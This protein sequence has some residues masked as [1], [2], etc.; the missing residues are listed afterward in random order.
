MFRSLCV[1]LA[2]KGSKGIK[3]KN[4]LEMCGKP[5]IAYTIEAA[6]HS[7]VF[8]K[9]IVSTDCQ[10]IA[11][12]ANIY[13]AETPFLRPQNLSSDNVLSKYAVKHA[14]EKC[15]IIYDQKFDIIAELQCTSPLRNSDHVKQSFHK[16]SELCGH[17]DS[18]I[19]VCKVNH[20]HPNKIKRIEENTIVDLCSH[21][22]ENEIGRRQNAANYYS[23]NGAIFMM[24]RN[25][26]LNKVSRVGDK[27]TYYVMEEQDSVNIDSPVDFKLAEIILREKLNG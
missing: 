21:F 10:H 8:D 15:E 2:R 26:I 9:V 18:L 5:L 11:D 25:C 27:S 3:N 24:T 12:I 7:N 4:I 20:F 16:F 17:Y 6:L 23:R 13:G 19:S 22:K 14:V 1:I